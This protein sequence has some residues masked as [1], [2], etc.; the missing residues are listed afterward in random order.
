MR[1]QTITR[2][3]RLTIS[4]VIILLI[5]TTGSILAD[6]NN[7]Q[8]PAKDTPEW[9]VDMFF[10]QPEFPNLSDYVTGEESERLATQPTWGMIIRPDVQ[11]SYRLLESKPDHKIYAIESSDSSS[12]VDYYCYLSLINNQWKISAVR[13]LALTGVYWM[14]LQECEKNPPL[15]D[16]AV[17]SCENARLIISSDAKLK[18]HLIDNLGK[19]EEIVKLR[20]EMPVM[21]LV[22]R[23]ST[24]AWGVRPPNKWEKQEQELLDELFLSKVYAVGA[25]GEVHILVGGILENELLYYYLPDGVEPPDMTSNDYIYVERIVPNWYLVK[26]T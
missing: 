4:V 10:R 1:N 15:D 18:Q 26:K 23:D 21:E 2:L 13:S 7:D 5:T 17:A 16:S 9:V 24:G 8:Q 25:S 11:I 3:N 19:F 6:D 20:Q 12:H 22:V 14:M